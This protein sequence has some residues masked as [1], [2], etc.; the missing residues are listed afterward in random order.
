MNRGDY[1][2]GFGEWGLL[3]HFNELD[4]TAFTLFPTLP[5]RKMVQLRS[6]I[7]QT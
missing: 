7:F 3:C 5:N 4:A 2:R 1:S 6:L